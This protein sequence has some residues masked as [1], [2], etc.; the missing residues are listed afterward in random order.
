MRYGEIM[1]E[2]ENISAQ[3]KKWQAIIRE[4]WDDPAQKEVLLQNPRAVLTQHGL[5]F[6]ES[7]EIKVH[8]NTDQTLHFVL[9]KKPPKE[10][11]DEILS[12]IVAGFHYGGE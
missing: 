2:S 5:S 8:E 9:P 1:N 6:P 10:L 7:Q 4:I 12:H 11:P 3:V